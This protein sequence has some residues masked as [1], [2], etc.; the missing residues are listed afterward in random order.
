MTGEKYL[1]TNPHH[2]SHFV[3]W[4]EA[5]SDKLFAEIDA[6]AYVPDNIYKHNWRLHDFIVW[7]NI[8]L[9][10]RR[11]AIP[12]AGQ[13]TLRR[14]M[15]NP[16]ELGELYAAAEAPEWV[17]ARKYGKEATMIYRDGKWVKNTV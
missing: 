13:R 12:G 1:T 4:D 10:H 14:V 7:D 15:A 5:E 16:Y 2:S 6:Y 3:G 11:D 8:A 9:T 17:P